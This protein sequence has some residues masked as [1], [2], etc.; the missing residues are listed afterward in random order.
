M[1]IMIQIIMIIITI[2]ITIIRRVTIVIISN[3][4]GSELLEGAREEGRA[5]RALTV[6]VCL[7]IM[8]EKM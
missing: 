2:V 4:N 5:H 7:V 1:I 3:N 6:S 8:I